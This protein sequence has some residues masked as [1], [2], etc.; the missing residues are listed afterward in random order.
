MLLLVRMKRVSYH[1]EFGG[2]D[3]CFAN[4]MAQ[5]KF[6]IPPR[7]RVQQKLNAEESQRGKTTNTNEKVCF[8]GLTP[9]LMYLHLQHIS[10]YFVIFLSCLFLLCIHMSTP[11]FGRYA[12]RTQVQENYA[13]C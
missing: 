2:V 13:I 9:V 11:F 7:A 12:R 3:V 6:G 5:N 4:G 1:C 10:S 8:G